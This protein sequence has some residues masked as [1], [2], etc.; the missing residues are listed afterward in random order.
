MKSAKKLLLQLLMT[1]GLIGIF[2]MPAR[3]AAQDVL[4]GRDSNGT[5]VTKARNY[6]EFAKATAALVKANQGNYDAQA[7]SRNRFFA[8][9]LIVKSNGKSLDFSKLKATAVVKG[10]N[11]LYIVQFG[12]VAATE[13]AMRT[14]EGWSGIEYV[15]PDS[16][17][18]A[19]GEKTTRVEG[20]I[21]ANDLVLNGEW[22]LGEDSQDEDSDGLMPDLTGLSDNLTVGNTAKLDS[23]KFNSWGV[24][25]IGANAYAKNVAARTSSSIKVAVVDSGVDQ[26]HPFL[27]SRITSDG[28]DF[29]DVDRNPYDEYGHGTHVS[30]IIVDCT[31]GVNVKILPVRVLG[32]DGNGW[33]SV[34]SSGI[35]YAVERGAKVINMSINGD[36][37]DDEEGAI[38]YAVKK[39]V[40]VVVSAGNKNQDVVKTYNCP[41]HKKNVICVGAIDLR[42]VRADFSNYGSTLDVMAPGVG[43]YS[44]VPGGYYETWDG[45]SMATPH[46]TALAAMMKLVHPSYSPAQIEKTIKAHCKDLGPKGYDVKYGYG[47]P[48]FASVDRVIAVKSVTLNKTSVTVKAG[49]KYTLKATVSP[50]NATNKTITWRSANPSVATVSGGV[51]TAK[52]SGIATIT[53]KTSNGKQATCK[54][55][56]TSS[57]AKLAAPILT[58]GSINRDGKLSLGWKAVNGAGGYRVN[59]Y[60][61]GTGTTGTKYL[62]GK[63]NTEWAITLNKNML[64]RISVSAYRIESGKRVYGAARLA[65]ASAPRIIQGA[66]ATNTAITLKWAKLKGINGYYIYRSASRESGYTRLARLSENAVSYRVTGLG[67]GKTYIKVVPYKII[68][69][70]TLML[71][72]ETTVISVN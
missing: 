67:S 22:S 61:Y 25:W 55:K 23:A 9:R 15:E 7:A 53:A 5:S 51:V 57:A 56:V 45:T 6:E 44:C 27:K 28:Y 69:G 48:Q 54:V 26:T 10:P 64:Y 35:Y 50:S 71:P 72:H 8:K 40:T 52:K 60:N 39:G 2:M 49:Q 21:P 30:G 41:A 37:T 58:H 42:N 11:G 70:K 66:N 63:S 20:T 68:N 59:Y 18:H 24:E 32:A 38:D 19:E 14:I 16:L 13:N 36:C 62:S 43:I 33:N 3:A 31:R 17:S 4:S 12:S 29:V 47:L 65:Y 46:V 34:I 1:C